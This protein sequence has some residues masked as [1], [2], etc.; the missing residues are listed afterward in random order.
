MAASTVKLTYPE[1]AKGS[2][3]D[4]YWGETVA[5]PYQWLESPDAPETQAWVS[6]QN[7]VTQQFLATCP[8][9]EPLEARL[10][11]VYNYERF[12]CPF[13][14]GDRVSAAAVCGQRRSS[15]T[16]AAE[17]SIHLNRHCLQ[18]SMCK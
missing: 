9:K 2:Q 15:R 6:A 4:E 5:D 1:T 17:R 16:S 7:K 3:V 8:D 12:S 14:R 11:E 18:L 10:K 13:R